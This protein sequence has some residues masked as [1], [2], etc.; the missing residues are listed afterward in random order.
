MERIMNQED[1]SLLMKL[2]VISS[3]FLTSVG[4][5]SIETLNTMSSEQEVNITD[6]RP[7]IVTNI[8]FIFP[9]VK[10]NNIIE[11]STNIEFYRFNI[12]TS[13]RKNYC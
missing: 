11:R 5:T 8:F 1:F 9:Q 3:P 4:V 10:L 12:L 6:N 13:F 2:I 7:T